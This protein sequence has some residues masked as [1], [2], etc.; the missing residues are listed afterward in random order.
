MNHWS[1]DLCPSDLV[2]QEQR[3]ISG[4][5]RRFLLHTH[6]SRQA[7][8]ILILIACCIDDAKIKATQMRI[9]FPP[10]AGNTRPV[11]AERQ[12]LADEPI[13]SCGRAH[14]RPPAHCSD[15]PHFRLSTS[16]YF[17][18]II[19]CTRTDCRHTQTNSTYC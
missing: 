15:G 7:L 18:L 11:I 5:H 14:I 6:P 10:L 12:P 13:E 4:R 2:N 16:V 9:A 17:L 1:S 8:W 3:Y 19:N